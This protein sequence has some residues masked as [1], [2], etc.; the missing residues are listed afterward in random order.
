MITTSSQAHERKQLNIFGDLTIIYIEFLFK[1]SIFWFKLSQFTL[2]IS[3]LVEGD[4]KA[5]DEACPRTHIAHL[6]AL[7]VVR[8]TERYLGADQ[9]YLQ[10]LPLVGQGLLQ[11]D[12]FH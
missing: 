11:L 4:V 9:H 7:V 6:K 3:Y 2:D 1:I 8:G 5:L 12:H 10:L